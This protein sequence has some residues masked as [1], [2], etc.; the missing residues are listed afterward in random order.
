M[1]L[2]VNR[3]TGLTAEARLV[4]RLRDDGDMVR[5][6]SLVAEQEGELV[7][8][9]MC[10]RGRI[11][12][13]PALGLGSLGGLP[14]Y[15]PRGVGLALMHGVVAAADALDE[16]CIVLPGDGAYYSRFD[17]TLAEPLGVRPPDPAWAEHF[18]LRRLTTWTDTLR[19]TVRYA[20]AFDRL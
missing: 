6:L 12:G 9:V 15:Q 1:L 17:F 13:Q 20:P 7:G 3:P 2:P 8:H 14:K 16:P 5:G 19:D 18:Q 4:E 10:S 11:G